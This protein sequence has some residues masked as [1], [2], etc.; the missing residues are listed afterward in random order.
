MVVGL[1]IVKCDLIPVRYLLELF[2]QPLFLKLFTFEDYPW[3]QKT[4]ISSYS[5]DEASLS[6][7]L[8]PFEEGLTLRVTTTDNQRV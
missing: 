4:A 2:N 8:R 3:S 6:A 7:R 1:A 5:F